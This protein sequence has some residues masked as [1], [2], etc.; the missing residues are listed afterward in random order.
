MMPMM[1]IN[2]QQ[3]TRWQLQVRIKIPSMIEFHNLKLCIGRIIIHMID[4]L[5]WAAE[6]LVAELLG[7]NPELVDPDGTADPLG[8]QV[9]VPDP[10]PVVD[11]AEED[12]PDAIDTDSA[13]MLLILQRQKRFN[14]VEVL[15]NLEIPSGGKAHMDI[16]LCR[17]ASLQ[18]VRPALINDIQKLQA[19][20]VHGYRVGAAV[21]YV[22]LTNE[23]GEGSLVSDVD[24]ANWDEHWRTRD[25]EFEDFLKADKDLCFMSN[26]VFYVWDGNHRLMAWTDHIHRV[27]RTEL[28]WHY[29]V[30]SI[31]LR[32]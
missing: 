2:L 18:V 9:E 7:P 11:Q 6:E 5:D 31:V 4:F 20:F 28:Q 1:G 10:A 29:R 23:R 32:T 24:R 27:H 8:T 14:S 26:R 17:M 30:R 15:R 21:F 12:D 19:D 3:P 16:L 22:S 13:Y 25:R